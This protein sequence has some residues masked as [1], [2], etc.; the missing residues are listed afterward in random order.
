MPKKRKKNQDF[1]FENFLV[2]FCFFFWLNIL[3]ID[4]EKLSKP[5]EN[6][7][8]CVTVRNLH[9]NSE[10]ISEEQTNYGD[11][12]AMRAGTS[13]SKHSSTDLPDTKEHDS[14]EISMFLTNCHGFF[15]IFL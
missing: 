14:D 1:F 11:I 2:I 13:M 7:G 12:E 9:E 6:G 15:K 4:D 10:A 8:K 3:I 5:D